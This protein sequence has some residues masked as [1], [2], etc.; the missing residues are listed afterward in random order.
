MKL[1]QKSK[2]ALTGGQKETAGRIAGKILTAQ[3]WA[4]DYLNRM[5]VHLSPRTWKMMLFVF[6]L[7]FGSYC[8]YLLVSAFY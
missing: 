6:C 3:R 5:T 1:F 4:S 8:L 2:T 7:A